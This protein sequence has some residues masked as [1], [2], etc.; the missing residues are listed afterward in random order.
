LENICRDISSVEFSISD[1]KTTL[2]NLKMCRTE[3]S[4]NILHIEQ[5][6]LIDKQ[7]FAFD[8]FIALLSVRFKLLLFLLQEK[9]ALKFHRICS[10]GC[11]QW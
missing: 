3:L 8:R 4:N 10:T 2:V 5:Q 9:N 6:E 7:I 11:N 1:L